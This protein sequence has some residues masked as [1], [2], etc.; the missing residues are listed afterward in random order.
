MAEV[1]VAGILCLR[2]ITIYLANSINSF[3]HICMFQQK[4]Q[5]FCQN[6]KKYLT[7]VWC[8]CIIVTTI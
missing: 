5:R 4:W 1:K 8:C 2:I 6:C 7:F 3:V